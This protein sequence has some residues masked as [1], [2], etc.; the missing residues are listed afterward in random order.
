MRLV[1]L[2]V[3]CLL[4]TGCGSSRKLVLRGPT[5]PESAKVR[6][7]L[8]PLLPVS[9]IWLS[10]KDG[11]A[12]A[13]GVW[14]LRRIDVAV[15]PHPRCK[16]ALQV[17]TGALRILDEDEL[18]TALAHELGHV[19]L[20]HVANR[21]ARRQAE[22]D[23]PVIQPSDVEAAIRHRAY[24]RDEELA[25]DRFAVAL[26]DKLPGAPGRGCASV[27]NLIERLDLERLTPGWSQ[28]LNT[29][30]TP[31]ARLAALGDICPKTP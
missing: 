27:M 16:F 12:V 11:C 19:H 2:L 30:P 7:A 14:Q 15:G 24:D 18:R 9:G 20:G 26:L 13:L 29:H 23:A 17:T 22:E 25:A 10:P 6:E 28:W 8:A 1:L 3:L 21:G 31:G 4:V 5:G